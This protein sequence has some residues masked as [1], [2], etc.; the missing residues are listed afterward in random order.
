MS[1]NNKHLKLI[2]EQYNKLILLETLDVA[3]NTIMFFI[4]ENVK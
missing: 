2:K 4:T 3:G 1:V